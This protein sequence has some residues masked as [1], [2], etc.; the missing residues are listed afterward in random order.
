MVNKTVL[1]TNFISHFC[2]KMWCVIEKGKYLFS[3]LFLFAFTFVYL[4]SPS[5]CSSFKKNIIIFLLFFP[6]SSSPPISNFKFLE[7]KQTLLLMLFVFPLE[8]IS[9]ACIPQISKKKLYNE[10]KKRKDWRKQ[11]KSGSLISIVHA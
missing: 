1:F 7:S 6:F 11:Q 5:V 3:F 9:F 4:P 2:L 10:K 8:K